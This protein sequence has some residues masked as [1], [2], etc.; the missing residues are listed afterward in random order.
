MVSRGEGLT[1]NSSRFRDERSADIARLRVLHVEMDKAVAAYC[2]DDLD[3]GHGFH[4]TP[5]EM[6]FTLSE[7]AR[8]E[9]LA[10]LLRLNHER[11]EEEVRAGLH[12]KEKA[13]GS[14]QK[15]GEPGGRGS[16]S[17][18]ARA[19]DAEWGR[20][21]GAVGDALGR[22]LRRRVET[23]RRQVGLECL[24]HRPGLLGRGPRVGLN[25]FRVITWVTGVHGPDGERGQIGLFESE[26][27]ALR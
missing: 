23:M 13:G 12:E 16:I 4:E 3:L 18:E 2:W 27:P 1:A 15:A 10:R 17:K 6:R 25:R 26:P 11:Y 8:R 9:V 22:R 14:K 20:G 5:Q 21:R 19:E 24:P 7:A